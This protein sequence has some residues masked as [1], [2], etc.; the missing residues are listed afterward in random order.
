MKLKNI[1]LL[2][3]FMLSITA[4]SAQNYYFNMNYSTAAPMGETGDYISKYSWRGINIEGQWMV[5]TNVSAGYNFGWNVFTEEI[6]GEFTNGTKTL[7]GTQL[8]Y[9]NAFPLTAE[10]RYHFGEINTGTLTP[11]IGAGLGTIFTETRTEMGIFL[12][13]TDSWQFALV[14]AAGVLIP[15]GYSSMINVGVKYNYAFETDDMM[16]NS[17]LNVNLGFVWGQ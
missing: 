1:I 9:L 10:A 4:L 3:L 5:K 14:P 16:A 7:Y 13:D 8:R 15:V 12:T 17:F 11:Y 2:S 6:T